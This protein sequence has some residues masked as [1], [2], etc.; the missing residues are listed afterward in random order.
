MTEPRPLP[1][2]RPSARRAA[3]LALGVA[4]FAFVAVGIRRALPLPRTE[5]LRSKIRYLEQN[6][7][8]F[9]VLFVGSSHL[10]RDVVPAVF[11]REMA[12]LGHPVRSF[13]FGLGG[14]GPFE[15]DYYL[16]RLLARRPASL[17]YVF[18]EAEEWDPEIYR[19]NRTSRRVVAWHDLPATLAAIRV[20]L[21]SRRS[22]PQR[23]G[24]AQL[25]AR[26]FFMRSTNLGEGPAL[27]E[28]FRAADVRRRER[29]R[30]L[31]EAERGFVALGE[32]GVAGEVT[33]GRREFLQSIDRYLENREALARRRREGRRLVPA[34]PADRVLLRDQVAAIRAAGA[35]AVYLAPVILR[36][37]DEY[38][39]LLERGV[40]PM[41]LAF[42]DPVDHPDLFA[43][44]V[45][46]DANHLNREGA[47]AFSRRLARRFVE[48]LGRR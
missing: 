30:A 33:P 2:P 31:L 1:T 41:L 15:A 46:Y 9:D 5:L 3:C 12:A 37:L 26:L 44:D 34:H 21:A 38:R 14:M 22:V 7:D 20:S 32:I 23:L 24:L 47:E 40:I 11:D 4:C 27:L 39:E 28:H 17:R 8:R 19:R 16:R 13:N 42:D 18:V 45:H 35:E 43:V 36:P 25:H 6:L 10:F 48:E 29:D